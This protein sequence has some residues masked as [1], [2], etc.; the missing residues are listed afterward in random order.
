MEMP[1]LDSGSD[2]WAPSGVAFAGR[3]LLVAALGKR[4]LYVFDEEARA[5]KLVFSSGDRLRD[6][7]PVG[8][9]I[10]VITTNRSPRAQGPSKGDRL[11]R[12]SPKR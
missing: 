6:V 4:G 1:V 8:R 3:E 12:L 2:T 11:L 5:L 7:T 10:Y 9:D